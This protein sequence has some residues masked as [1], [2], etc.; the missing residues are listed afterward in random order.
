MPKL[1][2][3]FDYLCPSCK[4]GYEYLI[5]MIKDFPGIEIEWNPCEAH[6][7]PEPG[8]HSD[9]VIQGMYYAL[10]HGADIWEYHRRM[11]DA[12]LSE[13]IDIEDVGTVAGCARDLLDAD[14]FKRAVGSKK[15]EKTQQDGNYYAYEM[16]GVWALP[17]Y[18]MNGKKLDSAEDAGVTEDQLRDFLSHQ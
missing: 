7:R 12:C 8:P 1:E 9:I 5:N 3:F 17:S 11:H 13:T 10:E 6:P 16:Q 4:S 2:V 14:D 15:Y 18:R